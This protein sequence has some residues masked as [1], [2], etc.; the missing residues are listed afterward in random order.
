MW[1]S[2]GLSK[3]FSLLKRVLNFNIQK[4]VLFVSGQKEKKPSKD[5]EL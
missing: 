3:K 1:Q 4:N 5:K 2:L